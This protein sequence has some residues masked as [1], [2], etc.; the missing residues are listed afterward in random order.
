M[1]YVHLILPLLMALLVIWTGCEKE[2]S[3][4]QTFIDSRDGNQ[5][6]MIEIG[7]RTWMAENL[8]YNATGSYLNPNN[9]SISYG[10]LY[11][12]PTVMNGDSSS[13]LNP[14][15]VQ[16][17]CPDGWHLPS[18]EEWKNLEKSLGMSDQETNS[19]GWNGTDQGYQ[20][21]STSDWDDNGNGNNASGFNAYPSGR[22]WNSYS[23]S[24]T[25]AW[26]WTSTEFSSTE[27]WY[28]YLHKNESQV[29]RSTL[30]K[31]AYA[32]SCRCVKDY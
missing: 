24:Y 23:S 10:R 26:F 27:A 16:G 25:Y 6:K 18:D 3:N 13:T 20:M 32:F 15:G 5:Y 2:D 30:S 17:I 7:G 31:T 28:R 1:K 21:K 9:Q 14:S 19:I 8:R 29:Y 11:E 22:H 4:L 12:W